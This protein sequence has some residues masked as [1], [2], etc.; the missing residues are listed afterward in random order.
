MQFVHKY[1]LKPMRAYKIGI[2]LSI[3]LLM[4]KIVQCLKW[5][6]PI[7]GPRRSPNPEPTFVHI[8]LMVSG[9]Q[10]ISHFW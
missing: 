1:T 3:T 2:Y 7:F 6:D 5:L 9:I 4:H 8:A 10:N